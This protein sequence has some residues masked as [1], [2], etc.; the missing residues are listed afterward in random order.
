MASDDL[1]RLLVQ[2]RAVPMTSGQREAQRRSFAFGN[3]AI[4]NPRVTRA[5]VERVADEMAKGHR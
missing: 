1:A 3:V 5:L 4:E 2:A